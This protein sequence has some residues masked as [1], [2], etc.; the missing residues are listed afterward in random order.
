MR[1]RL[2]LAMLVAAALTS[3]SL[4]Q[5]T[6]WKPAPG[7]TTLTLWPNGAPDPVPTTGPEALTFTPPDKPIANRPVGLLHN[8]S[9]PTIT[10][11][12]PKGKNTGAAIVVFPGG[13]Y[14]ILAIDLE[15]TEVCD[16][17]TSAG[18]NCVLLKYRVP[19]TGPYMT[20]S[21][22]ALEDAQR[23]LGLVRENAA[24]WHIDPKRIGVLGFSAGAHLAVAL[25]THFDKRLY[26]AV[27][28][29]DQ[30]SCRP[31]FAV[32]IYP[33][34]LADENNSFLDKLDIHPTADTPPS[35]IGQAE[36]DPVHVENSTTWFLA[37]KKAKVPAEL[38]LYAEG[39][40]GYGLRPQAKWPIT[41]WP[42]AV[43]VWLHTIHIL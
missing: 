38:H 23:A 19:N 30:Q 26:P 24:K 33:G 8:V 32:I 21:P 39:G 6:D 14:N 4:A 13:G 22:A 11:Y 2:M 5:N 15:G 29:A 7:H 12:A 34:Y 28:A 20:K 10:L 16:W 1:N 9:V 36:D 37:L 31:D 42:K 18:I 35:F 17:L 27:D 41:Y 3:A 40:H 25:S 43:E